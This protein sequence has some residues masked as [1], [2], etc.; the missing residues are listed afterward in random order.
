MIE[1]CKLSKHFGSFKAVDEIS[2]SIP[3]GQIVGLLG[4]NGA[5]KSTTMR[6]IT[7]PILLIISKSAD[8]TL[9]KKKSVLTHISNNQIILRNIRKF[10]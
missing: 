6:M 2:F 5:G 7:C 4:R 8:K 3:T 1:V 10:I 9:L